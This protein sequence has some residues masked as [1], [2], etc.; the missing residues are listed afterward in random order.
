MDYPKTRWSDYFDEAC[1]DIMEGAFLLDALSMY[2]F[3]NG[4]FTNGE[5]VDYLPQVFRR[6]CA[7]LSQHA[8]DLHGLKNRL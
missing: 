7:Y 2:L 4:E 5:R 6:L 3:S 8:L 1:Q